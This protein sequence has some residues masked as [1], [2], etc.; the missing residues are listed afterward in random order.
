M[1]RRYNLFHA[2]VQRVTSTAWGAALLSRLLHHLDRP[3]FRL[4]NGRMTLASLL[5]GLPVVMVTTTGAKSGQPRTVPLI[6]VPDPDQEGAFVL[7]A[8]NWGQHNLPAWYYNLKANPRAECRLKGVLGEYEASEVDG[9]DYAR[10]WDHAAAVYI[11]FPKY[12]VRA[13][14]RRI[15]IMRLRPISGDA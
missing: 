7:I 12:K 14:H 4:T 11:G 15:P 2:L 9:D 10:L 13:S 1:Q 6:G 3:V 8:S 5:S